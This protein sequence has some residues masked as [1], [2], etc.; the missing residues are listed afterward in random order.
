MFERIECNPEERTL[1]D[2]A[3]AVAKHVRE[4]GGHLPVMFANN[5]AALAGGKGGAR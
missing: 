4:N 5:L 3:V 2:Y 1:R